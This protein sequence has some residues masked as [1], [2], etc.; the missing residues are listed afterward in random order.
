[1]GDLGKVTAP[2]GP[3]AVDGIVIAATDRPGLTVRSS[4]AVR[5]SVPADAG[6]SGG[7]ARRLPLSG[8]V[9]SPGHAGQAARERVLA[10]PPPF[11]RG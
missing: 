1:V 7:W 10:N 2:G 9:P 11:C 8:L 4:S 5:Q 3:M 6:L